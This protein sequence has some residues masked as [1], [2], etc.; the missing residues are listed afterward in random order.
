MILGIV[1]ILTGCAKIFQFNLQVED[2]EEYGY[3]L[4]LMNVTG[5]IEVL[6][7]I[8]F[9]FGGLFHHLA[10]GA[11]ILIAIIL[12]VGLYTCL[13]RE[14]RLWKRSI[15]LIILFIADLIVM[16]GFY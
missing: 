4:W 7:G 3:P 2:W 13:T 5:I 12:L 6:C 10:V 11:S 9:V 1:F 15:F 16:I 8:A 14:K